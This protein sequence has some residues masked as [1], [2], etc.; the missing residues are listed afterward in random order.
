MK[1]EKQK[2][3]TLVEANRNYKDASFKLIFGN[4]K[5]KGNS[6]SLFNAVMGRNYS[7]PNDIEIV[8]LENVLLLKVMNDVALISSDTLCLFEQQSTWNENMPL[9]FLVYSSR[10]YEKYIKSN[11]LNTYKMRKIMIPRAKFICFYNGTQNRPA[12]EV[13][14]LS[15]SFMGDPYEEGDYLEAKVI[16]Y[17]LNIDQPE[18]NAC[19]E[20]MEYGW[21][22]NKVNEYKEKCDILDLQ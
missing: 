20:L 11:K 15:D 12:K 5:H 4:E 3:E 14:K 9:R 2:T 1:K 13:L 16:I 6:L 10:E 17:N 22:V 8:T 7:N 21:F 18:L 19:K